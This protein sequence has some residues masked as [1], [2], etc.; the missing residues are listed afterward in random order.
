MSFGLSPLRLARAAAVLAVVSLP[1]AAADH[2]EAGRAAFEANCAVCHQ[3][4]G[5]GNPALA[6]PLLSY[7]ARYA[8]STEGRRQ[9]ALTLLYG[10]FGD[11]VVE[12]KHYNFKMPSFAAQLDDDTIA[13]TLNYVVFDLAQAP[14]AL[15]RFTAADVAA[16]RAQPLSGA[17]V[18]AHRATVLQTLGL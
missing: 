8:A 4:S 3:A 5:A 6:P 13:Q 7:P 10:L 11:V 12:D 14:P 9:L 1:A 15:A 18:R 16:E 2:D 17:Q